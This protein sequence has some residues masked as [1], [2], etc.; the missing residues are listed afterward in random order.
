MLKPA[1]KAQIYHQLATLSGAGF[2]I[3]RAAGA[4]LDARPPAAQRQFLEELKSGVE[5]GATLSEAAASSS[6]SLG[7]LEISILRAAEEGGQV[8]EGFAHLAR[9]FEMRDRAAKKIRRGLIYPT[10]LLHLAIILPALPRAVTGA[11]IQDV[12]LQTLATL[13]T[14]YA[15][16]LA[17]TLAYRELSRHASNRLSADRLLRKIPFVG[18]VR[19]AFALSRFA[20][21]LRIQLQCG[22]GP[23]HGIRA[24]ADASD[25]AS[26]IAATERHVLP[27]VESGHR[28]GTGFIADDGKNFP[29]AFARG[30]ATSEESGR[31]DVEMT[32]WAQVFADQAEAAIDRLA[33]GAPKIIYAAVA[34]FVIYQ[35]FQLAGAY[36]SQIQ[37]VMDRMQFY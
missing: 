23:L 7:T 22:R 34:I 29:G 11:D 35:V 37:E 24:A 9:Y 18:K 21:V 17:S 13:A 27:E 36:F 12:A 5:G 6:A 14:A 15:M 10:I 33:T 19:H 8:P 2:P 26:L 1:A 3:T 28:A 20:E 16:V 25:S 31:I 30:Y 32:R 4:A